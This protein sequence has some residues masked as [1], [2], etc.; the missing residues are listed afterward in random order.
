[1]AK[2]RK[3]TDKELKAEQRLVWDHNEWEWV[4]G[5]KVVTIEERE[6]TG[7]ELERAIKIELTNAVRSLVK[8]G[9]TYMN[10]SNIYKHMT[11]KGFQKQAVAQA[12]REYKKE[13]ID[14]VFDDDS[15]FLMLYQNVSEEEINNRYNLASQAWPDRPA[16]KKRIRTAESSQKAYVK[17]QLKVLLKTAKGAQ[18]KMI[19]ARLKALNKDD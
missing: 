19:E 9:A 6:L 1:M 5:G 14:L 4:R 3:K 10:Q 16:V 8:K 12:W 11:K 17:Q 18:K 2:L 15:R 7:D 13:I